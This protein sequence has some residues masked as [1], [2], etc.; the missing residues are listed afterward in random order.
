MRLAAYLQPI[1]EDPRK[2]RCRRCV[3]AGFAI[4]ACLCLPCAS[5]IAQTSNAAPD[6]AITNSITG[7][8]PPQRNPK[9][10]THAKEDAKAEQAFLEGA[11][12]LERND[13][14]AAERQFQLAASLAPD[15]RDYALAATSV[16]EGRVV[17]LIHEAGKARIEGH[18][19]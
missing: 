8:V 19:I 10:N 6:P 15:N 12:L 2:R 9:S 17:E 7:A 11:K 3:L 5:S 14:E 16:R 4:G 1:H 13:R 18:S